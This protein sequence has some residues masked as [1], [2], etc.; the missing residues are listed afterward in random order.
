M[1]AGHVSRRLTAELRP[2]VRELGRLREAERDRDRGL[3]ELSKAVAELRRRVADEQYA[4]GWVDGHGG[5][6]PRR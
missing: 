1:V 6:A 4:R 5:V 3:A 2:V